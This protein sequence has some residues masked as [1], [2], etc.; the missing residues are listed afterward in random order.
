MLK[1]WKMSSKISVM[2]GASLVI[3]LLVLCLVVRN[4]A[5]AS[6]EEVTLNRMQEASDA[7]AE[8]LRQYIGNL[9]TYVTG[10]TYTT[11]VKTG[12][13]NPNSAAIQDQ[14]QDYI[15]NYASMQDNLEGFFVADLE[16]YV[17]AHNNPAGVGTLAST[18]E[19]MEPVY[20]VMFST[21]APY[22]RGIKT[23]PTTGTQV[24][25]NYAPVF[26]EYGEGIGY[27]GGAVNASGL[28]D[29]LNSLDFNGLENCAFLLLDTASNTFIFSSDPEQIG[30]EVTDPEILNLLALGQTSTS[31]TYS[32]VNSAEGLKCVSAYTVIPE[33]NMMFAALDTENEVFASV[34]KLSNFVVL[35]SIIVL[36]AVL[37]ITVLVVTSIAKDLTRVKDIIADIGSSMDMTKAHSLDGYDGR[38]DEI[39]AIVAATKRLTG[40]VTD[41]VKE[42]Q[43]KS[44]ELY[45]TSGNLSEIANQTLSNVSQVDRAVQEIAEGATSQAQETEKASINVVEMGNQITDTVEEAEAMKQVSTEINSSSEEAIS[46]I[47]AL[48]EIG[49]KARSAVDD[50]YEQTNVTNASA[51]RIKEATDIISSIAEE[52]NLLSLNASI[53]AARAGEAGRGFAVVATQIQKLAEQSNESAQLIEGITSTLISDSGKAVETM[54]EVKT[55]MVNQGEYVEKVIDI[56][57]EVKSGIDDTISGIGRISDKATVM[58]QSRAVVVDTVQNLSA[59]AE[60]NAASAE[61]TSASA[62]IVGNLMHDISD[63]ASRL[64]GIAKE[65]DESI[66]MFTV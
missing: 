9:N 32:F 39:G 51:Q 7:R 58:D 21:H 49:S 3:G 57:G 8:L 56:F 28:I 15:D 64:S 65:V 43:Q 25:V 10:A 52:T 18:R 26:S 6:M 4:S 29:I 47:H 2:V 48:S 12:L 31:G 30:Q 53:E 13:M 60:E 46:V 38:T 42:L 40:S 55:I 63:S 61:E 54:E 5:T 41:A 20:D 27:V 23:S 66:S 45:N 16:T 24:V 33:Y 44:K 14:L 34:R 11:I 37:L 19:A 50:I 35:L 59:I 22:L 36:I 62:S 1:N 17:L